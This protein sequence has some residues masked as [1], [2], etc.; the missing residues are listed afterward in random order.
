MQLISGYSRRSKTL[1]KE[2]SIFEQY[3]DKLK[4]TLGIIVED[5]FIVEEF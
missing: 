1:S 2:V 3:T 5:S 4:H